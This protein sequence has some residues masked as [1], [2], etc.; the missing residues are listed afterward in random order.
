MKTYHLP[1][2]F[3]KAGAVALFLSLA[4]LRSGLAQPIAPPII[5]APSIRITSP[6]NHAVFYGPV[7]IPIF[8]WVDRAI[9]DGLVDSL[10]HRVLITNVEF[11]AGT[12]NLGKAFTLGATFRPPGVYLPMIVREYPLLGPMYGLVWSNAPVGSYALTAV[13][14]GMDKFSVTSP[15]VNITVQSTPISTNPIDVVDILAADPIAIA[16]SNSWPWPGVTNAA[17]AWTNWPGP[18]TLFT[19]WGPKN[20]LFTVRR[21]GPTNASLTVNYNIGGTAVNGVNYAELTGSV[22]IAAGKVRGL[23]PI[24]PI[25]TGPPYAPKTV[26]LTLTN[27]T[28]APADYVV[29]FPPR[30]CVLIVDNWPRPLPLLLPDSGFHFN[31]AGPDGAWF[32]MAS[33]PDLANWTPLC[34]NQVVQGAIDFLDPG[35]PGNTVQFYRAL[36]ANAPPQ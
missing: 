11:Y 33:S 12:S 20:G 23:I 2:F 27:S 29:G 25:D 17:P 22:T 28:A 9:Y 35:A 10:G 3:N 14:E 34:T 21:F 15:P 19:N 31:A 36:P 6:P 8:A 32:S 5:V 13:A 30:A 7:D 24:V 1:F 18:I 26:V 4:C 16:T